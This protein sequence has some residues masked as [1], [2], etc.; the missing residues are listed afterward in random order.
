MI[1]HHLI[2]DG[3]LGVLL[4]VFAILRSAEPGNK[5]RRRISG[6]QSGRVSPAYG[7]GEEASDREL[8]LMIQEFENSPRNSS[9]SAQNNQA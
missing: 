8:A 5:R 1:V 3:V 6:D 7:S 2:R 4:F 9:S